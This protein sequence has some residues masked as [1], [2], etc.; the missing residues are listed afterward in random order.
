MFEKLNASEEWQTYTQEKALMAD[1]L[2]GDELQTYFLD[3]R[4]KHADLLGS[5]N[6]GS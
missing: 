3:E 4:A 5:S 2:T 1:F 6:E